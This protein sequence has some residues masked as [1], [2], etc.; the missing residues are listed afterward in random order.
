LD[1]LAEKQIPFTLHRSPRARYMRI[2]IV[3]TGEVKIV[4]PLFAPTA[5]IDQFIRARSRWIAEKRDYFVKYPVSDV[6]LLL[7]KRSHKEYM[8]HKDRA[9]QVLT[10][11]AHHFNV[12]YLSSFS[13]ITIRNQ[14]SRWG[15]CSKRGNISFNYKL[16][17]LPVELRDYIVVHELCHLKQLNHSQAFWD[18][19]A[20]TVPDHKV[21]R[22][23]L[24]GI[25]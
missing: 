3:H 16:L 4:A 9:L 7:A 18:L 14:R 12:H 21:L 22:R 2:T 20:Q 8:Q 25:E 6:G 1:L 5:K 15:S 17:F 13:R 23:R 10:E 11:R 24:K 19:V